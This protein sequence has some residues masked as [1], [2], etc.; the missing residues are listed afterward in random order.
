MNQRPKRERNGLFERDMII[1]LPF[2]SK[3]PHLT[4]TGIWD[5]LR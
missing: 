1:L 3:Y 2:V 5:H 4:R